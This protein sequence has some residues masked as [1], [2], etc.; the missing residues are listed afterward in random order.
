MFQ[1]HCI[2]IH[3]IFYFG[4]F[5]FLLHDV[6]VHRYCHTYQYTCF[7]FFVF[8]YYIW[9]ICCNFSVCVYYLIPQ[10]CDIIIIIIK[11][12]WLFGQEAA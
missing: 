10:H 8:N 6:P 7:L 4:F 11:Y 9:P 2:T 5:C 12:N 3:K 1:I